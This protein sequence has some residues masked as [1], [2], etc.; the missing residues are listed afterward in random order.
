[1]SEAVNLKDFKFNSEDEAL[2]VK[3]HS[4]IINFSPQERTTQVASSWAKI[5]KKL[6]LAVK[7]IAAVSII[8][9]PVVLLYMLMNVV[10]API[11][12]QR[13]C[14]GMWAV[15][16]LVLFIIWV[17]CGTISPILIIDTI[18]TGSGGPI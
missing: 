12:L 17:Q 13:M 9:V 4:S 3:S 6:P 16:V 11:K 7:I 2:F 10:V 14:V 1:M 5:W 15:L 8:F 18:L